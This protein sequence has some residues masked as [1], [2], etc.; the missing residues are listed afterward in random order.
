M[1]LTTESN[2]FP[3]S[4]WVVLFPNPPLSLLL[5]PLSVLTISS[6]LYVQEVTAANEGNGSHETQAGKK[7]KRNPALSVSAL[8]KLLE[9]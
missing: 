3:M 5:S 9:D 6:K 8:V 7:L 1:I 2:L 4:A